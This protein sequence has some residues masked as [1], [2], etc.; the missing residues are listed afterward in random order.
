M[1]GVGAKT[2]AWNGNDQ[3]RVVLSNKHPLIGSVSLN[4]RTVPLGA[5]VPHDVE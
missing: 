4:M 2:L 5:V 1:A 3:N